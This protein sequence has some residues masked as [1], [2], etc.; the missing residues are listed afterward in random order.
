M[1]GYDLSK[2]WF[3]WCFENPELSS[4]THTA[5]YFFIIEHWNRLGQKEKFGLPAEMTKDALGIKNYRTFSKAFN[6]LI[7]WGFIKIHQRSKNQYSANVIALVKNTNATT[8][9]LT[10]ATQQ[11][12][13]KQ[14]NCIVGVD[15]P[16][17]LITIKPNNSPG[18]DFEKL[19]ND[20]MDYKKARRESYKNEKSILKFTESLKTLSGGNPEIAS[21]IIDQ[22]MANN[23][24]G[25]F[26]LK[27]TN[28]K[29]QGRPG[30]ILQPDKEGEAKLLARFEEN[31]N[32]SE[33]KATT[34]TA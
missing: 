14:R 28:K 29:T 8:K 12:L 16:N 5:M 27:T 18:G 1:T 9:A 33:R 20:W 24:A 30:Q 3:D 34:A 31:A 21:K 10:K 6:D 17:N 32:E 2:A 13:Q 15:K 26:E 25:I 11:Q 19:V 7:E 23:W 22:S 4:C